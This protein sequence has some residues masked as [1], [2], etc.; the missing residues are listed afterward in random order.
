MSGRLRKFLGMTKGLVLHN[1]M[2]LSIPFWITA[3]VLYN[4]PKLDFYFVGAAAVVGSTFPDLDHFSMYRKVDHKKGIWNFMKYCVQADRYRKAFL[5]FH[6]YVAMLVVAVAAALFSIV[7]V[8]VSIFFAAFLAHLIFDFV[9]DLYLIKQ[10]THWRLRNWFDASNGGVSI[11]QQQIGK[12]K[13][14]A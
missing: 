11:T 3:M 2:Q 12:Q 6:N 7:N 14:D 9:A 5:P 10:H 8:Y 1:A 13:N 4:F